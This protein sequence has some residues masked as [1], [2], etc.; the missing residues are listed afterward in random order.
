MKKRFFYS[1]LF[2]I[3]LV[4]MVM[5]PFYHSIFYIDSNNFYQRGPL[6][7]VIVYLNI[8]ILIVTITIALKRKRNV[9]KRAFLG[10]VM[11]GLIPLL[12][13]FLQFL[14]VGTILVWPSVALAVIF[15]FLFLESQIEQKDY[16]TGL[17][18]RQQIDDMIITR[19]SMMDKHGGFTLLMIDMDEFKSI[20]DIHGHKEGDRALMHAADLI[21]KSVRTIDKVARFGGDEFLLILEEEDKS[22]VDKVIKRIHD[23][24]KS[25]NNNNSLAYML[26]LSCGYKIV[27]QNEQKS[28]YDLIHEADQEMYLVKRAKKEEI[29]R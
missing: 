23:E 3:I 25:F 6:V 16:L 21:Y 2:L 4:L 20:N 7:S 28:F 14:L 19:I 24:I 1:P 22:E 11:F 8:M 17:L 15:I 26:K 5:N 12:G 27:K 18:N 29:Q 10:L 13:N 9:G